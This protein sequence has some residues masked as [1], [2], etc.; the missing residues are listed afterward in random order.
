MTAS[1]VVL[2]DS[3]R[4]IT[5]APPAVMK[6]PDET[7]QRILEIMVELGNIVQY[8]KAKMELLQLR[9]KKV[10]GFKQATLFRRVLS[11]LENHHYRLGDRHMAIEMFDKNV[12]RQIVYGDEEVEE[13]AE[14]SSGD[15][16]RT[17][18]Q[19]SISDPADWEGTRG[20]TQKFSI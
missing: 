19:R 2:P 3:Q 1:S 4:T 10:P 14:S 9:H 5:E 17:E 6:D 7:N 18:R 13:E 16:G 15:E 12:L 8:K 20:L 11:L